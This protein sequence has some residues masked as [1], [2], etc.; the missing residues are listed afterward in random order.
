MLDW[1]FTIFFL[2]GGCICF[3]YLDH[4][5]TQGSKKGSNRT[6][7]DKLTKTGF[8]SL[9]WIA[10]FHQSHISKCNVITALENSGIGVIIDCMAKYVAFLDLLL[11]KKK[12]EKKSCIYYIAVIHLQVSCRRGGDG[13][14]GEDV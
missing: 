8:K 2:G 6:D 9:Y 4:R 3:E 14:D 10:E 11:Q 7:L 13:G 1:A 12:K 5:N